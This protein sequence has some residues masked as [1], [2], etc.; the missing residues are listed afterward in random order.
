MIKRYLLE[1]Q[2]KTRIVFGTDS[3]NQIADFASGIGDRAVLVTDG[4]AY[5]KFGY[6]SKVK[7]LLEKNNISVIVY[8]D[9]NSGIKSDGVDELGDL[10]RKSKA[11]LVI[12]LGGSTVIN[13]TKAAAILATNPGSISD[14]VSGQ[15]MIKPSLPTFLIPTVPGTYFDLSNDI[16][17]ADYTDN[18]KK[19][20]QDDLIEVA[21]L[22]VDPRLMTTLPPNVT[23][24]SAVFILVLAI[25]SYISTLSNPISDSLAPRAIE[26]VQKNA[27]I[28]SNDRD[29]I[30]LRWNMAMAGI[31]G[32]MSARIAGLG[33]ASAMAF[34]LSSRF[35]IYQS[36]SAALILPHVMEFNL[37][38]VPGK[39]VQI[40]RNMGEEVGDLTVVEA[41]IKA[42]ESVRKMLFD[43]RM[44][45]R[46]NE[47]N[48]PNEDLPLVAG[49]AREFPFLNDVPRPLAREDIINILVSAF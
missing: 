19:I 28:L 20:F 13:T 40:A 38:A 14:Y 16:L 25:E 32:S 6:V 21:M 49:H 8:E 41:A 4:V 12:G 29:N 46:L 45:Q 23:S 43:L 9:V 48:I 1:Y 17:V 34:T 44:P 30:E 39:Y 37:T 5:N 33:T 42:V 24:S 18:Y 22:L 10:V 7:T 3:V 27:K 2:L 11:N 36:V 31:L 47:F 35:N 15:K 26:F